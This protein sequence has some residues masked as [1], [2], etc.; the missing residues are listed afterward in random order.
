MLQED[1]IY[2]ENVA[3]F[4]LSIVQ[5]ELS[6][7]YIVST[8]YSVVL[9]STL[10]GQP[11]R[12]TRRLSILFHKRLAVAQID[13]TWA[14]FA[15]RARRERR[16]DFS[17]YFRADPQALAE[18]MVWAQSRTSAQGRQQ[19]RASQSSEWDAY[20]TDLELERKLQYMQMLNGQGVVNVG[21]DP[22]CRPVYTRGQPILNTI[23]KHADLLYGVAQQRWLTPCELALV[24]NIPMA[25]RDHH[26]LFFGD[27][28]PLMK[29][30]AEHGLEPRR[31]TEVRHQIGNG[32]ALSSMGVGWIYIFV[33]LARLYDPE[34]AQEAC[35]VRELKRQ[36]SD[37]C[38]SSVSVLSPQRLRKDNVLDRA[39]GD[40]QQRESQE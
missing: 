17:I 38:D 37:S 10:Y 9:C 32:Q 24:H 2:H 34:P 18:E 5:D 22:E 30:R 28:T 31:R 13:M 35:L 7:F 1:I 20:L 21:Q 40:E 36:R 23:T 25:A 33:S 6:E 8:E 27:P 19:N 12:R 11:N 14:T 3:E 4:P 39:G 29:N 15:T 16:C 26:L